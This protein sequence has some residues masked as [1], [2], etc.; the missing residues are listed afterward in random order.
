VCLAV[1]TWLQIVGSTPKEGAVALGAAYL[2]GMVAIIA[3]PASWSERLA[4]IDAVALAGAAAVLMAAPHW[5]LFLD[6]LSRAWTAYDQPA[7]Q[8]AG[9]SQA[10]AFALGSLAPG[11]PFTGTHP[12]FVVAVA[13]A[14]LAPGALV[15]SGLGIGALAATAFLG[16]V[17]FGIVPTSLISALPLVR[18]IHHVWDAFLAAAVPLVMVLAGTGMAAA[19]SARG[20]RAWLMMVGVTAGAAALGVAWLVPETAPQTTRLLVRAAASGAALA[21]VALVAPI[22]A[23]ARAAAVTAGAV[24]AVWAC[25]LHLVTGVPALDDVL[26]QPRARA[27]IGRFSP[28][29]RAMRDRAG[30]TPYRVAPVDTVLFPG[31]QGYW[32]VEGIGGPDAVRLPELDTLA[33]AGG[34]VRAWVWRPVLLPDRLAVSS[35]YLDMLGARFAV[36]RADQVPAGTR[37]LPV[38]GDDRLSVIERPSAWPRAF[39]ASGARRVEGTAGFIGHML[40][41]TGPFAAFDPR[42]EAAVAAFGDLPGE[43]H[44]EAATGYS[45]TPSSTRFRIRSEKPGLAVLSES[46]VAEDFV[47]TLN[48]ERVPYYRVNRGMKAVKIPGPGEWDVRFEYRPRLWRWSWAMA[49]MGAA[50]LVFLWRSPARAARAN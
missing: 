44:A 4:R 29:L 48:G 36:A 33:E 22:P 17:A 38:D 15:R 25:G 37:V 2:A 6:T 20:S 35:A 28:A 47:A 3:R 8:L 42:D 27:D 13:C 10:V 39:F 41:A 16:A 50:G 7:V 32:R 46:Y 23:W 5:L 31:T 34:L 24:A 49:A 1:A 26:M 43:G 21:V 9:A 12:L 40:N 45:L 14:L 11:Q 19:L 18:N 30:D